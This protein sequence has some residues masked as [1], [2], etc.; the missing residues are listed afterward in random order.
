MITVNW[1][2]ENQ[3]IIV[4]S[5]IGKWTWAEFYIGHLEMELML[6]QVENPICVIVDVTQ[7]ITQPSDTVAHMVAI[8]RNH[9]WNI[10]RVVVVAPFPQ[11][12][13]D[14]DQILRVRP[15]LKPLCHH[16]YTMEEALAICQLVP[17]VKAE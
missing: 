15:H 10:G 13:T 1:L 14:L 9:H 2:D 7:Q 17:M 12:A 4:F 11:A 8:S 3:E 16:T 5:H 6:Y